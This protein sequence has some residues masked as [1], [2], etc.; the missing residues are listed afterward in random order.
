MKL[1]LF[2]VLALGTSLSACVTADQLNSQIGSAA[3]PISG[4]VV[5]NQACPNTPVKT[6]DL[7]ALA[8]PPAV[9]A[10]A[11]AA[12]SDLE[13][14]RQLIG[15][16]V[17]ARAAVA[18]AAAA[19][20]SPSAVIA[21]SLH[22]D[23]SQ[24]GPE[25]D[26]IDEQ[27]AKDADEAL[28][29]PALL[30]LT[31]QFDAPSKQPTQI[32]IGRKQWQ[33]LA[34][35]VA[36][37]TAEHGWTASFASH[38]ANYY[39]SALTNSDAAGRDTSA[40]EDLTKKYLIAAY[41]SAYFRNGE[42]FELDFNNADIKAKV[43]NALQPY[44]K[45]AASAAAAAST[46][47]DISN[48]Y[49]NLLCEKGQTPGDSCR[50]LGAIGEQTFVTRAGKSYGFPGITATIDLVANEKVSTNKINANDVVPDL[51]RVI[52]EATGDS[53]FRVPGAKN[54]TLCS[55]SSAMCAT[56]AEAAV[57]KDVDSAG[58]QTEGA[59]DAAIGIAVRGGWLIS[60]NNEL[61]ANSITTAGA[62][63][64]RKLAE[65]AEWQLRKGC[66]PDNPIAAAAAPP[67]QLYRTVAISIRD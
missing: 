27:G 64:A 63:T 2:Y 52:L 62:V 9:A 39:R 25:A 7:S 45:D 51:I 66:N 11:A 22:M 21:N 59:T 42:I 37:V 35:A 34:G 1:Q 41:L 32:V 44:T 60:L 8:P 4:V 47:D 50:V 23:L 58:D 61:L 24:F 65:A 15:E 55:F 29:S 54:S 26:H 16:S 53:V 13:L 56:D 46:I 3:H 33:D 48:D 12:P 38:Y 43:T 17:A 18:P 49:M 57:L 14:G 30:S 36:K 28:S 67:A 10:A 20:A 40:I 31:A 19:V 6:A 5:P